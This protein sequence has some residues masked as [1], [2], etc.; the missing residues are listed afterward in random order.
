MSIELRLR[1]SDFGL[2]NLRIQE[3]RDSGI[4]ELVGWLNSKIVNGEQ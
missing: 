1:I 2:R 3:F 4:K